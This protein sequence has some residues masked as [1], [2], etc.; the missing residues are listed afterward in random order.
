MSQVILVC[1]GSTDFDDSDRI[2]G[3][4]DLPLNENGVAQV[5]E[6]LAQL[7]DFKLEVIYAAPD[8]S[9]KQT[10][11]E[12]AATLGIP[13]KTNEDLRNLNQGLWQ[14]LQ[15]DEVRR[16]YPRVIKQW[17]ESPET[18]CPPGGETISQAMTR[19]KKALHKPLSKNRAFAIVASDP[20]YSLIRQIILGH[21]DVTECPI[22]NG[23]RGASWELV[24]T[25]GDEMKTP[26]P[27]SPAADVQAP[28]A[29]SMTAT[30][31]TGVSS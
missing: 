15:I 8:G 30:V 26:M 23:D 21:D 2:Q 7:Q 5:K 1:P 19:I 17:E 25:P 27:S 13:L 31:Q 12:I 3:G 18:I 10:A 9:A 22:C 14:G 11:D 4:L 28:A 20:A 24:C 6:L 29:P 16:K